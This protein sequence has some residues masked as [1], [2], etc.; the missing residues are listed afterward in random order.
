MRFALSLILIAL[1][2]QPA[3]A[4]IFKRL[5]VCNWRREA[6]QLGQLPPFFERFGGFSEDTSFDPA[7]DP[8]RIGDPLHLDG[9]TL[10]APNGPGVGS[11]QIVDVAPFSPTAPNPMGGAFAHMYVDFDNDVEVVMEFDDPQ[12]AFGAVFADHNG[13]EQVNLVLED[14]AHSEIEVI[15]VPG[16]GEFGFFGFFSDPPVAVERIRFVAR[17]Q[18]PNMSSSGEIFGIDRVGTLP[19]EDYIQ[20]C[21][22]VPTLPP[23]AMLAFAATLMGAAAAVR[24]RAFWT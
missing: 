9:F 20:A 23:G 18:D 16:P 21:I 7:F 2:A 24:R 10:E 14:A 11:V 5:N 19:L 17:N 3:G 22:T 1:A 13:G 6:D 12:S 15:E 8:D 4:T